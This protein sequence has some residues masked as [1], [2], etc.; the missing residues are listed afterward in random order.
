MNVKHGHAAGGISPTYRSWEQMLHRCRHHPEYAGRGITFDPR[1]ARFENFL[2]DMGERPPGRLSIDRIDNDGNYTKD[3]CRWTT[4]SVQNS[5]QR[6]RRPRTSS[7]G[8]ARLSDAQVVEIFFDKRSGAQIGPE[9]GI[10]RGMV[11]RIKRA[12][13]HRHI[14]AKL[15]AL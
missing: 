14:T 13:S 2:A 5:N 10:D 15:L 3:N 9:Y 7:H 11:N 1:W 12:A 8:N 4:Y 6:K